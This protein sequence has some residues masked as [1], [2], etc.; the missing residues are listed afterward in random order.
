MADLTP[1]NY[2]P[3]GSTVQETTFNDNLLTDKYRHFGLISANPLNGHLVIIY[4]R[5][6][7]HVGDCGDIVIRHSSD[8]GTN[9]DEEE[10]VYSESGQGY[11][12]RTAGGGY[13]SNGRLFIFFSTYDPSPPDTDYWVAMKYIY[14]NND[15]AIWLPS[16]TNPPYIV[17]VTLNK[18]V[19]GSGEINT[20]FNPYGHIVDVGNNI[21]YQT[22][23]G[24]VPVTGAPSLYRIYLYKSTDG[25]LSFPTIITVNPY[26]APRQPWGE[27]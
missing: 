13:D 27:A 23:F 21:L 2:W 14:S 3:L 15:G 25:G 5:G 4:R 22:W 6:T 7:M 1:E 17:H 20:R 8:G 19:S 24:G 18:D 9:W 10:F 12:V 11:D 26:P 16:S